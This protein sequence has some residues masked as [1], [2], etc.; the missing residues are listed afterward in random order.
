VQDIYV[1]WKGRWHYYTSHTQLIQHFS[2]GYRYA[3]CQ[4]VL[5]QHTILDI[6][7]AQAYLAVMEQTL[8]KMQAMLA[9]HDSRLNR[10]RAE[11]ESAE[12]ERNDTQT[13]IRIYMQVTGA[14]SV[15]QSV[16]TPD[17]ASSETVARPPAERRLLI[18]GELGVG[19]SNGRPPV[20]V[21]KALLSKGITDVDIATLRTALWRMANKKEIGSG[22]GRYWKLEQE[23]SESQILSDLLG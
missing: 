13:A 15:P 19:Q 16:V 8:Q 11:I 9:G 4:L 1:N 18:L 5:L 2:T 12:T 10:L 23:R 20:V 22:D 3:L 7:V 21:H 14:K 6:L 17:K